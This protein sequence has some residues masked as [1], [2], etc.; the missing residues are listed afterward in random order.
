MLDEEIKIGVIVII[1]GS[2]K[3]SIGDKLLPYNSILILVDNTPNQDLG[4]SNDYNHFYLPLRKNVGIAE[5]QNRGINI[6]IKRNCTHVIFFDQDSIVDEG[7]IENMVKEYERIVNK[8]PKLF[9]LGPTIFNG[10]NQQEYKSSI[11]KE[12]VTDYDFIPRREII[13]SG[14]CVRVNKIQ[15]VGM[16]EECLFIDYVDFEWCWRANKIGLE[17]GITPYVKLIHFVGQQEYYILGQ[18]IIISSPSRYFFQIRNYLWLLRSKHVPI[19]WKINTGLKRLLF[20]P[21]IPFKVTSWRNIYWNIWRGLI[22]G[23]KFNPK[24]RR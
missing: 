1:Y 14:S 10:R 23:L 2:S 7:F 6:A 24:W 20:T 12:S 9:L 15:R 8:N 17:S 4:L 13:S 19:A 11:H 22:E 3:I 18:L 21:T 5:A 16:L